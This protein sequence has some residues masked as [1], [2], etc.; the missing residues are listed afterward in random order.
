M[1]PAQP[2]DLAGQ[3]ASGIVRFDLA[4]ARYR[5]GSFDEARVEF[6]QA[7][8]LL[9]RASDRQ[10][11]YYNLGNACAK[12]GKLGEALDAYRMAMRLN[13]DDDDARYNYALVVAWNARR[14]RPEGKS[15][16]PQTLS[17]EAARLLRLLPEDGLKYRSLSARPASGRPAKDW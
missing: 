6:A 1:R 2:G 8:P 14:Q 15:S 17:G 3:A 12:A 4:V 13:P 16:P 11:A 5:R 7:I 10:V 9:L